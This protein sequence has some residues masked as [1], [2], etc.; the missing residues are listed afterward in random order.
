MLKFIEGEA[1]LQYFIKE[2]IG[3]EKVK[4]ADTDCFAKK[5]DIESKERYVSV[6][7]KGIRFMGR[8]V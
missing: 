6:V 4:I 8:L 7:Y 1:K 3:G 5:F 2:Y